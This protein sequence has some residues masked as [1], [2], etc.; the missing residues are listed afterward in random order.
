MYNI[1]KVNCFSNYI[2]IVTQAD[3]VEVY[4]VEGGIHAYA[5]N[6]DPSIGT[7]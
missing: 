1:Y 2:Y 5:E 6:V 4:N 3:F 7:Y